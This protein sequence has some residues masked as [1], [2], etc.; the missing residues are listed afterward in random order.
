VAES[1]KKISK[2]LKIDSNESKNTN[3]FSH[4][5]SNSAAVFVLDKS[6]KIKYCNH[7][8]SQ[9][10]GIQ[11]SD[12]TDS[13]FVKLLI[14]AQSQKIANSKLLELLESSKVSSFQLNLKTATGDFKTYNFQPIVKHGKKPEI[15]LIGEDVSSLKKRRDNIQLTT[16]RYKDLF[17]KA[18]NLIII[19][20]PGGK[21]KY[22]NTIWNESMG[23]SV[24]EIKH[25]NLRDIIY[26][27]YK[28]K[29]QKDIKTIIENGDSG[30]VETIFVNSKNERVFLSGSIHPKFRGNKLLELR[31]IFHDVTE[32][33][34]AEKAK[35]LYYSI[36][37]HTIQSPNLSKLY[38]NIHEELKKVI[39][40]ENFYVALYDR[41]RDKNLLKFPYFIDQNNKDESIHKERNL[42][43]GLTE[44]AIFK[45]KPL[46]LYEGDIVDLALNEKITIQGTIPLIWL[47]VPLRVDNN[48]IGIISVQSYTSRSKY[49][50]K[51]LELLDF[52]SGQIALAIDIKETEQKL[53]SQTARLNAIFESS[54]HLIWS[55][56]RKHE[57]TSF[58]QNYFDAVFKQFESKPIITSIRNGNLVH[59]EYERFWDSKYKDAFKGK[60]LHFEI[61]LKDDKGKQVWKDIFLNPIYLENNKI[62]EVSGIATDIT[63]KKS[64]EIALLDSEEKFRTIFE[65]FQDL[66]FRCDFDG[67]ITMISPSVSEI[68]G[69]PPKEV[70]GTKIAGYHLFNTRNKKIVFRIIRHKQLKNLEVSLIHKNGKILQCICNVRLI[71][72]SS[73]RPSQIEGIARDITQIKLANLE[74]IKAKDLAEKS[75]KVK[76][77]F[78]A[79]MSHEIRTPMNGIIGMID[80]LSDTTLD[81]EQGKYVKAIKKSSESLLFILND[82]LDLSKIEAGKMELKLA[83]K[84]I[85][86]V[87]EKLKALFAQQAIS[88]DISLH[89]HIGKNIPKVLML[90]ETR[91]LQVLSNLTS[92]ALKFTSSGGS[93]DIGVKLESSRGRTA[94]IKVEVNDSGIGISKEDLEIL[95]T[96]F[97][98]VDNSFSKSYGGTGL[99]LAISKELCNLMNGDIG[100]HS[101]PGLGST[102]WFTFEAKIPTARDNK[103]VETVK[104]KRKKSSN[105]LVGMRPKVL[106]VDDNT[107]N[108]QVAAQ[109]LKKVGCEV[110]TAVGGLESIEIVRKHNFDIVFMDIQMP[111]M[112]GIKATKEIRQLGLKWVPPIIAMTAYSMEEDRDKFIKKGLDDYISKPLRPDQLIHTIR[113]W[114]LKSKDNK[115][116]FIRKRVKI[117]NVETTDL[118]IINP[119]VIQKLKKYGDDALVESV[120]KDFQNETRIQLKECTV[121]A[122][123]NDYK[124]ILDKLHTIKGNAGTLGI[125]KMAFQAKSI[126]SNLHKN[127]YITLDEDLDRLSLTFTEFEKEMTSIIH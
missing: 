36:A 2:N 102:F 123:N 10:L 60:R 7:S 75:L 4:F 91:L 31:C 53:N 1:N 107:V 98:Q 114:L 73:G 5:E 79:N 18:Q 66:Y 44:Y 52:I 61:R 122:K 39:D 108:R 101:N 46:F 50:Q 97:N 77:L 118:R 59:D 103:R 27:S 120:L 17:E 90:D 76:E 111:G 19:L 119:E 96:S 125:E 25:L 38:R 16:N 47:G 6:F 115:P 37:N 41:E 49:S 121:S 35:D 124:E 9:S 100:V 24:D 67:T 40:V 3:V 26:S 43:N 105:V 14:K 99:G 33:I 94:S 78:L 57:L 85:Q 117:G 72:D 34:R 74:L 64:S 113:L 15:T 82:I 12:L 56:N 127:Y 48:I 63:E 8:S 84:D 29:T 92:N 11:T 42:S 93:V 86:E 80:L 30:N 51:D 106:I 32:K 112:D 88:K 28:A 54:S 104:N 89:F 65:S 20:S 22:V 21:I 69:Y 81:R 87:L 58:N 83:P 116:K 55:V 95:F 23:F 45:N 71:Y 110:R 126:E 70:S 68:L 13:D 62:E 109:I